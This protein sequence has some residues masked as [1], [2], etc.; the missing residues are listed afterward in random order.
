[1]VTMGGGG[2]DGA[3]CASDIIDAFGQTQEHSALRRA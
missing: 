1:M 3:D 2:F